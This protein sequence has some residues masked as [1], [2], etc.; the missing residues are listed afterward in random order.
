MN[1]LI[2]IF[3]LEDNVKQALT[4][5][6]N[7]PSSN[8]LNIY[9]SYLISSESMMKNIRLKRLDLT[10]LINELHRYGI[11]LDDDDEDDDDNDSSID[12]GIDEHS[13]S[14]LDLSSKLSSFNNSDNNTEELF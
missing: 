13:L 10:N 3:F 5:L 9:N 14:A 4:N 6:N 2:F 12:E 7:N 8:H 1:I 11:Y